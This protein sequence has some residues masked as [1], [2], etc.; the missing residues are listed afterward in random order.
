VPGILRSRSSDKGRVRSPK[1]PAYFGVIDPGGTRL[2]VLIVEVAG[3][4]SVVWGWAEQDGWGGLASS[5]QDLLAACED[6]LAR[7][8]EMARERADRWFL[9]DQ[10]IVGLPASQLLGRAWP[11]AQ[12]RA[13]PDRP[14]EERELAALLERALRLAV[15]R[16][17]STAAPAP[18]TDDPGWRLVE[19][20]PVALTVDGRG[21]T[22]PVG[23]RGKELG[24]TVF[25]A[26]ARVDLLEAW[27]WVAAQLEFS[28][29][30]LT[31]APLALA[32]TQAGPQGI[33]MDVGGETT[34]LTWWRS[35]RPLSLASLPV[36]S[37][38]LTR[39][40]VLGWGLSPERAERLKRAYSANRL[41][42]EAKA[43]V[44]EVMSDALQS[45]LKE[46]EAG[47]IRLN[48]SWDEPMPERLCLLGGGSTLPVV[49]ESIAK[50]AWSQQ[51]HFLRYPQV[52]RL[53]PTDVPGVVNRSEQ[54]RNAGDVAA[55]ALAA[56]AAE[57][58][59]SPDRPARVLNE[60]CQ[61]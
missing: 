38:G 33:L 34:D 22:D 54:G 29:L 40:L 37:A 23:F 42:A 49:E 45:W 55:L 13:R 15:N 2:R 36:G 52:G 10:M 11:V 1:L 57:L 3:P 31:A 17:M 25:A 58:M 61:G 8:E 21:V 56:W 43:Q 48:E 18:H 16:L 9:P 46:T 24:A 41:D 59:R 4:Q 35:G 19:A 28:M 7:A 12:R 27:Q 6:L 30:T 14:V 50:L 47:L 60:L 39:S 32:T 5:P 53:R 44:L 26:L 51:L 20:V